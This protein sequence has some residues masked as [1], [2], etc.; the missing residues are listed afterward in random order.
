MRKLILCI[1]CLAVLAL[2]ACDTA[3][4]GPDD[5][6]A[7][8]AKQA[9]AS[10]AARK[11]QQQLRREARQRAARRAAA[12]AE[13]RRRTAER[14]RRARQKAKREE[15]RR[16]MEEERRRQE[17]QKPDCHPSYVGACLDPSMSD[18]DCLGGSG[19]GPGYTGPVTVVG[20]DEYDLDRDGDG[21]GCE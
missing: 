15:E 18:Y 16:A 8:G 6:T 10:N 12:R 20:Y 17:A 1:S 21:Y 4:P 13:R 9:L 14:R 5:A 11:K 19:D 3:Q 2:P 7:G